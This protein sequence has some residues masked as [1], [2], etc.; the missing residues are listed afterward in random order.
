M[1]AGMLAFCAGVL[2]AGLLPV[3]PDVRLLALSFLPILLLWR[4]QRLR[5]AA[6]F[7]AG[8][9]YLCCWGHLSLQAWLPA[10]DTALDQVVQ[11]RIW[12]VPQ[13]TERG[14]RV[15]LRMEA[16]CDAAAV[17][18]RRLRW[19]ERRRLQVSLYDDVILQPG[20][21]WQW[22]LRLRRPHGFV[23][24]GGFDYEAWLLQ[25]GIAATGYVRAS[26]HNRLL[27][28]DAWR[29]WFQRLRHQLATQLE[30][31]SGFVLLHGGL[32]QALTLGLKQ[33]ISDAQWQQFTQLGLNHLIVISGLHLALAAG[34]LYR[35]ALL[36]VR[37]LPGLLLWI[38][39]PCAAAA[40][41]LLGTW[42]YAGLAGFSL[43]VLRALV[44]AVVFFAGRL[45]LRHTGSVQALQLAL[46]AVLLIDPLAPQAPGFW[47]SFGAVA[48]LLAQGSA[49]STG[50]PHALWQALCLQIA[51]GL[52]LLPVMWLF[53]QQT[54][55]LAPLANLPAIPW[56]GLLVVPICL[57]GVLLLPLWPPAAERL[58]VL[59]DFLL[60]LFLRAVQAMTHRWP[61]AL[62]T[63]PA[64]GLLSVTTAVLAIALL[65]C[66]PRW[67]WR[68]AGGVLLPLLLLLP[69]RRPAQGELE[70]SV[71]DV[72]QGLA[73]L[74]DTHSQRLLYDTGPQFS[75]RFDAGSDVL[76][77]VLRR[78]GARAPDIV[79]VS[80]AD[81]DHAGGLPAIV[82]AFPQA[83]YLGSD[84]SI[85]TD[86]TQAAY[87]RPHEWHADG[88][89]FRVLH[90]ATMTATD[91]D[92]S[93]VLHI[94]GPGGSV[95]LPGD[96]GR[97]VE[98]QLLQQYPELRASVLVAAHHGSKTSS[99]TAF[100]RRLQPA[101]VIF[102]TGYL[103]RFGHPATAIQQRYARA[104]V[105]AHDTARDGAVRVWIGRT[106][107]SLR[108]ERQRR[109][110]PRFWR[111]PAPARTP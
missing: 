61:D 78:L 45:L 94:S 51:L 37:A 5:A 35:C 82:S 110:Q 85:F 28:S 76:L 14:W 32:I 79:I 19:Y 90:P 46:C 68:T 81:L 7:L 72:G 87:C 107:E 4:W 13:R 3:L 22:L 97:E 77:P 43:P 92:G 109:L 42:F 57:A 24:P 60:D 23:N 70:L 103:N 89:R 53:F 55:L 33:G 30:P 34:L 29:P 9:L 95:L 74:V 41:A 86:V 63:L 108:I 21:L 98:L 75:E 84:L 88:F 101:A 73:V 38:P 66:G 36:L 91:N 20:Q 18:C 96:I 50:L 99:A 52:G 111:H 48:L 67:Y 100:I 27:A 83:R 71:L 16:V 65:L 8:A 47:L 10:T 104:G 62:F 1:R 26:P 59:G 25:Q 40:C 64:P 80:H 106:P 102:S 31:R 56:I 93:C 69:P 54:S 11:G 15:Q 105:T 49:A 6:A 17:A 39:A 2:L 44:M 58:L 12:S